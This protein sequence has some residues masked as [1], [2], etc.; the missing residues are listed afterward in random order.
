[1]DDVNQ[2]VEVVEASEEVETPVVETAVEGADVVEEV[3]EVVEE[4]TL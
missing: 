2:V 4:V 1:M 3:K